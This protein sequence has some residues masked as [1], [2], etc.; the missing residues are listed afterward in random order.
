[1]PT[2]LNIDDELLDAALAVSGRKTKRDA[3]NLALSEFV[4][5]RKQKKILDLFGQLEWSPSFDYKK[6]RARL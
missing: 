6:E 1:M 3:V 5:R 2:N 4:Q